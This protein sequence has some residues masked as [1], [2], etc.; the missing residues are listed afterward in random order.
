MISAETTRELLGFNALWGTVKIYLDLL[1]E[2]TRHEL[3]RGLTTNGDQE[4]RERGAW[5]QGS[6]CLKWYFQLAVCEE[7]IAVIIAELAGEA[8]VV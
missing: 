7:T 2:T 5:E 1:W 8:S 6:N 3:G 4:G